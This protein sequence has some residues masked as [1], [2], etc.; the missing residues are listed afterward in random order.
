MATVLWADSVAS[1]WVG[2]ILIFTLHFLL[3]ALPFIESGAQSIK[4]E[5]ENQI[6]L[7]SR[8]CAAMLVCFSRQ[9]LSHRWLFIILLWEYD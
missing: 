1:F 5:R 8:W 4:L 7:N 6:L 2:R 3:I 9:L